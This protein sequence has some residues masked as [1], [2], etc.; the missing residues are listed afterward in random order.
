MERSNNQPRI[1]VHNGGC[2]LKRH[3]WGGAQGG[4]SSHHLGWRLEQ[5]NIEEKWGLGF[6]WLKLNG[7]T[8][9]PTKNW[10]SQWRVL[11]EEAHPW[12]SM[13]GGVIPLFGATIGTK[14]I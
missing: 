12:W 14:K 11:I 10:R 2:S 13:G 1:G 6:R 9:Q 3:R 5:Q 8:Q 4:T 7:K